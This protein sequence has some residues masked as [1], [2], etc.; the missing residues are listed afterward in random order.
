[1][2]VA[3]LKYL[4]S[5]ILCICTCSSLAH[6]KINEKKI[7]IFGEI[8]LNDMDFIIENFDQLDISSGETLE[9]NLDSTGGPVGAADR[10]GSFFRWLSDEKNVSIKTIVAN[11][12]S[13]F[14]SCMI[15][16]AS[17]DDRIAES[18][19]IFL[20][21]KGSS[22]LE[23][24]A[25]EEEFVRELY[26]SHIFRADEHFRDQ[27]VNQRWLREGENFLNG[28]QIYAISPN[29]LKI[30]QSSGY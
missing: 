19:S 16:F 8:S 20:I 10:I 27:I 22:N 17:G 12:E 18:G 3:P 30:R 1:M 15:V 28:D 7:F 4:A 14:S 5:L 29:F 23:T 11:G 25:A 21:H 2:T 24:T 6:V 9:V 26:L 13:C